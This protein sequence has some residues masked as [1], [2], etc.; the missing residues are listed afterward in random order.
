M[1][2]SGPAVTSLLS[3]LYRYKQQKTRETQ[4]PLWGR[5]K[6]ADVSF[7]MERSMDLFTLCQYPIIDYF[8]FYRHLKENWS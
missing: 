5:T 3:D 6:T 4:R 2:C 7:I 1:D 8:N